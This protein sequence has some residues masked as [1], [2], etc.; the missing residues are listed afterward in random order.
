LCVCVCVCSL[1]CGY[2]RFVS[3]VSTLRELK[4]IVLFHSMSSICLTSTYTRG[5]L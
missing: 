3:S 5:L 2:F 4:L 1:L